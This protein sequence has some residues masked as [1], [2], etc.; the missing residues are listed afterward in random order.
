[1]EDHEPFAK[2]E[3][4]ITP[5]DIQNKV[6]TRAVRGYKEEDVD[7]FLDLLTVD[8]ERVI[9]DNESL[10]KQVSDMTLKLEQYKTTEGTV[11]ETLEAAKAL[12][13]DISASAEKRAEIMV[14]NAELDAELL[15]RQARESVERLKEEELAL[16]Q[17]VTAVRA[18]FKSMLESELDR[19]DVLTEE[20][21]GTMDESG[22]RNVSGTK[23]KKTRG[24]PITEDDLFK[25][26]TNLRREE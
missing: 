18:R 20:L 21:F 23:A 1:M 8:Y 2:G 6:F 4:M 17:R 15:Q 14:K 19:F 26:V 9:D 12:M 11:I 7:G 24:Q 22:F 10:R 13:N 16:S 25:T 3:L 5:L